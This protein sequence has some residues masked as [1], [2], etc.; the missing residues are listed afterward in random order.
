YAFRD[1]TA[2]RALEQ[3]RQDLVATVSHEL[4]TPLAAIFGSAVTLRR[5][6]LDL[7]PDLA[8]KLLDVIY[9]EASRLADIVNDLLLAGPLDGGTLLVNIERC[10][11]VELA[12]GVVEAAR[13]HLPH[14]VTVQL[15]EAAESLA[16]VAADEGQ[17]GQVLTNLVDNAV[18]YS[19]DGGEVRLRLE[20]VG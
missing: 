12:R 11:A 20:P 19:P 16:P 6:D 7:E 18:K 10:D 13:T 14:D 2:E 5:D 15:E 3:V 8:R 1:L 4:R 17:L 9:E